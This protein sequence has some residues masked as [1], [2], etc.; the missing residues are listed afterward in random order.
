MCNPA[1]PAETI[2]MKHHT[3]LMQKKNE[4]IAYQ[5]T[6]ISDQGQRIIALQNENEQIKSENES[7]RRQLAMAQSREG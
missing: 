5:A 6:N 7:L 3:T 4:L 2:S 1:Q